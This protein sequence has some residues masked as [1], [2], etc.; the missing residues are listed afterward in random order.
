MLLSSVFYIAKACHLAIF[1]VHHGQT[2][3]KLQGK[4]IEQNSASPC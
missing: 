1:F 2:L 3:S 4:L